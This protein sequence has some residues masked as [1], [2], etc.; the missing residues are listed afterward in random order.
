MAGV[1]IE[2]LLLSKS[3]TASTTLYD[4][5]EATGRAACK[6]TVHL[7]PTAIRGLR[8]AYFDREAAAAFAISQKG[9]IEA[10]PPPPLPRS[11]RGLQ[12]RGRLRCWPALTPARA[13]PR[14][15]PFRPFKDAREAEIAVALYESPADEFIRSLSASAR[16][17]ARRKS[18]ASFK[19]KDSLRGKVIAR[20]S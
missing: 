15:L 13:R 5:D 6:F 19:T 10:R 9:D 17:S 18:G 11:G 8:K 3:P 14:P 7:V 4:R 20:W 12:G 2:R 16:W 1:D